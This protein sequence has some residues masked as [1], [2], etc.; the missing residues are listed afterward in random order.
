[1]KSMT[2]P[3][4]LLASV[5]FA[6]VTLLAGC[7]SMGTGRNSGTSATLQSVKD[8]YHQAQLQTAATQEALNELVLAEVSDLEQ[9]FALFSA[10][11]E[12]M[13][14]IGKRLVAHADG[15]YLRGTYYF[16]ESSKSLEACALPRAAKSDELK[17][18]DLGEDFEAISEAGGEIKRAFRAYQFDIEQVHCYLAS[19]LTPTGIDTIDQFL[20]KAAVDGESLQEALQKALDAMER[21]KANMPQ[22]PE[23][24]AVPPPAALP[25]R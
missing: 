21:A 18:I 19:H 10:N 5:L 23:K 17:G 12:S 6:A 3:A 25:P 1:M 4:A 11:F 2:R 8:D 16:V 14:Q 24:T 22:A 15:M 13:E 20:R 9:S 7:A